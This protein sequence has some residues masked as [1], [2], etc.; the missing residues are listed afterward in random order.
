MHEVEVTEVY[1]SGVVEQRYSWLR[2]VAVL[3]VRGGCAWSHAFAP[4]VRPVS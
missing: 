4:V 2:I 1:R 3:A